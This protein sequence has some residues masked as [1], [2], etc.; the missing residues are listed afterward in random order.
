MKAF[1]LSKTPAVRF[2]SGASSELPDLAAGLGTSAVVV[3]GGGS[4]E[5]S[6]RLESLLT[7]LKDRGLPV[8]HVRVRGEPSPEL[9]DETVSECRPKGADVVVAFG[10]GSALDAGKA[11]AAMLRHEGSVADYLEGVGTREPTGAR[12]A[13]IA[14]PTTAGTGSEATKNAV[15]SRVG[16]GGYKKSLR[17]EGFI[18][19]AAV[20]DPAVAATCSPEV[21]AA[22]GVDAFTQLLEGYVSSKASPATDALAWSGLEHLKGSLVPSCGD[23]RADIAV[24]EPMAYAAY[25]SGVVLANAG[26][27]IIHGLAG[28]IGGF[29]DIPHGVICGT[30]APAALRVNIEALKRKGPEGAAGLEKYAKAGALLAGS[31]ASDPDA[32][33][34]ALIETVEGWVRELGIRRL[35][36][37][38]VKASDVDRIVQVSG[39]KRNPVALDK[40]EIR[41]VVEARL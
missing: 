6:G 23:R 26:L 35:G 18:P 32:C 3:T 2:G 15:L 27:G 21:L 10:G 34:G 1:A 37:Y 38:G 19:D 12:A 16:P 14:A 24:R 7:R 40:S 11:I 41:S 9:I 8:V 20:I 17:H 29:F 5:A 22:C 4:L 31:D 25:Q 28:P 39:N 30:L 36:A 13:L 33:R